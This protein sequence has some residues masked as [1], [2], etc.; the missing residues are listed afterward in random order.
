MLSPF[1]LPSSPRTCRT[2][3]LAVVTCLGCNAIFGIEDPIHRPE[4]NDEPIDAGAGGLSAGVDGAAGHDSGGVGGEHGGA[5]GDGPN[6]AA[7]ASES[8]GASGG[9]VDECRDG[10]DDCDGNA[11][12]TSTEGTF[13]CACNAGY[14]GDGVSCTD[15]DECSDDT[16]HCDVNAICNNT[17]GSFMCTC[18]GN[19]VGNG[20]TCTPQPSCLDLA[21]DCGAWSNDDCCA[22]SVVTGGSF[23]L[24]EFDQSMATIATFAL[25]KYE[26]T[27]GRFRKFVD[28]YTGHPADGAGA[29]ALIE[30][31]GWQSPAWDSSIA[32]SAAALPSLTQCTPGYQTWTSSGANDRLPMN[33]V[34]WYEAFA[35]CVWDGGRLPTEAEWEYAAGGAEEFSFPWGWS[36]APSSANLVYG[37]IGDGISGCAFGDILPV[38]SKPAGVGQYGQLDLSGLLS[39]WVLDFGGLFPATCDNCANLAVSSARVVR[40]GDWSQSY[41]LLTTVSRQFYHPDLSYVGLRCARRP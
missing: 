36:V 10:T 3:F 40:G 25:D 7:G 22:S 37:C 21:D 16:D 13:T 2:A 19:F 20:V 38:G 41:G 29:H 8:A 30:G 4:S 1:Q 9:D 11:T 33:C 14:L 35:F 5:A 27:V 12:C 39:E 34:N 31:S 23:Y 24:G 17:P 6:A 15:I 18:K 28:A 32:A 26:V